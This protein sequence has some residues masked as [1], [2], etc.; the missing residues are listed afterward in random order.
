MRMGKIWTEQIAYMVRESKM[1]IENETQLRAE[2]LVTSEQVLIFVSCCL[3]PVR[4]NSVLEDL[5]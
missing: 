4:R 5:S 1:F 2:W 3:R